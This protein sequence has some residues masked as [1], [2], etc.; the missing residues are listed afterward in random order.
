MFRGGRP[1]RNLHRF[2]VGLGL[3]L[4]KRGA[5]ARLRF[6]A[7]V[8]GS[9]VL[10]L[11]LAALVG[12]LA[13]TRDRDARAETIR[14]TLTETRPEASVLVSY[15]GFTE[16]Q[17]RPVLVVSI[18]PL[19]PDAPLPPGVTSWPQPGQ[20]VVSPQVA[21]DLAGTADPAVFGPVAGTI[22]DA[23]LETPTERR[24]YLRPT[25]AALDPE[26]MQAATGFG[27]NTTDGWWGLGV[28]DAPPSWE[29]AALLLVAVVLPGAVALALGA[30][31]DQQRRSARNR[32]LT[33]AGA[34][35]RDRL[36]LDGAEAWPAVALGT[37]LATAAVA[38]T[39]AVDI[40]L[41]FLETTLRAAQLRQHLP[42]LVGAL[43]VGHLLALAVVLTVR[44]ATRT[45]RGRP[46]F[47][48]KIS[49]TLPMTRAAVGLGVGAGTVVLPTF[50]QSGPIR[51]LI[52]IGGTALF[53]LTLPA[54]LA[55][56][57]AGIGS[58]VARVGLRTG[59][60][61]SLL[62]GRRLEVFPARTARLCLGIAGVV[63]ALGQVQLWA[64]QLGQQ[65]T[66]AQA[67]RAIYGTTVLQANHTTYGAGMAAF[68]T[69][70]DRATR[71][72]WT[73][74]EE[75]TDG[76][77]IAVLGATC[78]T[79]TTLNLGC[80][81]TTVSAGDAAV[82]AP[83]LRAMVETSFAFGD[84][85]VQ[86]LPDDDP[87]GLA[88]RGAALFL[89][90]SEGQDLPLTPASAAGLPSHTRRAAA[91]SARPGLAHPRRHRQAA[92]QL[93]S[94]LGHHRGSRG[95]HRRSPGHRR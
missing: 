50:S 61:G 19:R 17:N 68:L 35:R 48:T 3:Q 25:Q 58:L 51:T 87:A 89:V 67:A 74:V 26:A 2:L 18:W 72:V 70:L 13:L 86:P 15:D 12:A 66:N 30:G 8:V 5:W 45:R 52:Y 32:L 37:L 90:S 22:A 24:V 91:R 94:L 44:P 54:I 21:D 42:A 29:V 55:V 60:V 34:R 59:S 16:I 79:L 63:L 11:G 81:A 28:L 36:L 31:L 84:I 57:L 4:S 62:G 76:P 88:D 7:L 80:S 78:P 71:P 83:Q 56:A 23:G 43:L 85:R 53:I 38:V 40:R 95:A 1:P 6:I 93:D 69:D 39:A 10:C 27:G 41:S 14:P 65:Y 82:R 92:R 75:S 49:Q 20:A 9:A 77:P 33:I 64:S 47:V 46:G 73:W